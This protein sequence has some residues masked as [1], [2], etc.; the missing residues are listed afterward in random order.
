MKDLIRVVEGK[1][2]SPVLVLSAPGGADIAD[3]FHR[4]S[5]AYR[6]DAYAEIPLKLA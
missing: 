6:L 1:K 4:V 3:G 2:L 5:L